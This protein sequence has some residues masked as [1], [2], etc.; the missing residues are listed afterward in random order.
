M[1]PSGMDAEK[2]HFTSTSNAM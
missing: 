1:I 2:L